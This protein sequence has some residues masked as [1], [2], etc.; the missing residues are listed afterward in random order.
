[1]REELDHSPAELLK[2]AVLWQGSGERV[3]PVVLAEAAQ[4]AN[5]LSDHN[6]S[7]KLARDSFEQQK[8]FFAQLELGWSL[9]HQHRFEEAVELLTP[10]VGQEP[11]ANAR[12]RW[13]GGVSLARGH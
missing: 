6:L 3:D 2:L 8:T 11:G 5:Q 10:L 4:V 1:M 9:L 13:A 7:E 12:E